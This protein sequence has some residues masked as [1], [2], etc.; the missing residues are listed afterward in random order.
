MKAL[1]AQIN[2]HFLYNMLDMINWLAQSGQQE[3][4]SAAIQTLSK[5]YKLTLSKKNITIPIGEELRHV[6]LYV[7]LQNMRFENKIEFIVDVPDEIM[8]YEI[9]KLVL[10]PIVENSILHGIFERESKAGNIVIMAWTENGDIIFTVSDTGMG[11]RPERL[12]TILDGTEESEHGSNIG[13]YNT[14]MRL[15]YLYGEKYGLHFES[16][17]GQGTEVQ[18]R[19]PAVWKPS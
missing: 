2:P 18:V 12:K 17:Y 11:I 9:P 8:E 3:K 1:Q 6:S 10:Q 15:K 5:F 16:N 19:I 4:V 14:H 13:I 7:M